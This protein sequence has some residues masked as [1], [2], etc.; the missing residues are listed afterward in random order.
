MYVARGSSVEVDRIDRDGH[1]SFERSVSLRRA[2]QDI[3]LLG[4]L[5]LAAD[6]QGLSVY[7]VRDGRLLSTVRTCGN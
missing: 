5:L 1:V 3:A 2:A 4:D 6:G 7:D